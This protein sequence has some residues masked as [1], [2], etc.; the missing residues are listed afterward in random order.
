MAKKKIDKYVIAVKDFEETAKKITDGKVL[1]PKEA[2]VYKDMFDG[3]ILS[4]AS[5]D[6]LKKFIKK[7]KFSKKDCMHYWEGLIT[8]DYTL[9]L[10]EYDT[11][12][13][14]FVENSCDNGDVK[15]ISRIY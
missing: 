13:E 15:F 11:D 5:L 2:S 6:D 9:L 1:M 3:L 14:N 8:L 12:D 7:T 10:F 4:C